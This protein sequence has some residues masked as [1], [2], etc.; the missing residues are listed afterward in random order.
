[1]PVVYQINDYDSVVKGK[2]GIPEHETLIKCALYHPEQLPQK[3]ML[4]LPGCSFI[5]VA[6]EYHAHG[7]L[8]KR[9]LVLLL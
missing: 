7:T 1:M 2:R 3:T 9:F 4:P 6:Y 8:A 5:N